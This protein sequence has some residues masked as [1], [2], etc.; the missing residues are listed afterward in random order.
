MDNSSSQDEEKP[1]AAG[2]KKPQ[3]VSSFRK[4]L[5]Q[6]LAVTTKNTLATNFGLSI[7][8]PTMV[9]PAVADPT[10]EI[11]LTKEQLSW[12]G[13]LFFI[14][15]PFGCLLSGPCIHRFGRRTMM[16]VMCLPFSA[17]WAMF[18]YAY[19]PGL[20][21]SAVFVHGLVNGLLEAPILTYVAEVC[22][23]KWRGMFASTTALASV[24]GVFLQFFM[25]NY[26]DW[27]RSAMINIC[28]PIISFIA[29]CF[30]PE[31]PHWLVGR[32]RIDEAERALRWLRGWVSVESIKPELDALVTSIGKS[33]EAEGSP[34]SWT[35]YL[36]ST[37]IRPFGLV[38]ASFL[39]GHFTGMSSLQTYAVGIFHELKSPV[40]PYSL[41]AAEGFIQLAGALVCI[42]I[43]PFIG[44]RILAISTTFGTGVCL[45]A[46][47]I[48]GSGWPAVILLLISVFLINS[49]SK[50]FPWVLIGEVFPPGV[51]AV[52]S[53]LASCFGYSLGFLVNKTYF[54]SVDLLTLHG[55]LGLYAAISLAGS[56][57][58]FLVLPETEGRSLEE[59]QAHFRGELNLGRGCK[60]KK[61]GHWNVSY[62]AEVPA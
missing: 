53:G 44:R 58:Y 10:S 49:C 50:V 51:R 37:F 8:F 20:L 29:L 4:V 47:A 46:L 35:P 19:N 1:F 61:F 21:F 3:T 45:A 48:V 12:L 22:E 14:V 31:S 24:V 54:L 18:S 25:G 9:I 60:S 56:L 40:S 39:I 62:V 28:F 34:F 52:A 41:T 5:P 55:V 59:V 32:G 43:L 36:N 2:R 17:G 16:L 23:P 6:L 38:V 27:R 30:I 13:S 26:L 57:F 15:I 7:A 33:K 11:K 42:S